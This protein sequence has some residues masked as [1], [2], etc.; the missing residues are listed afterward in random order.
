ML[1]K[2]LTEDEPYIG[3]KNHE[4]AFTKLKNCVG[5][6]ASCS[7]AITKHT[8]CNKRLINIIFGQQLTLC[9]TTMHGV[10]EWDNTRT[11]LNYIRNTHDTL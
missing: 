6:H 9:Y 5:T 11:F 4:N 3:T 8:V 7:T 10:Q 1:T 2:L